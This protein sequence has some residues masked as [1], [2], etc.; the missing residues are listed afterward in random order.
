MNSFDFLSGTSIDEFILA[1]GAL[2]AALAGWWKIVRPFFRAARTLNRRV[3]LFLDQH[4]ALVAAV[5]T[6]RPYTDAN[7]VVQTKA[8]ADLAVQIV[9]WQVQHDLRWPAEAEAARRHA[10]DRDRSVGPV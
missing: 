8:L 9:E 6:Q 2:S 5:L 4:E 7:G 3:N 10:Q 1:G